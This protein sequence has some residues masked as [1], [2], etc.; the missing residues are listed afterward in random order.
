MKRLLA[1]TIAGVFVASSAAMS[2]AQENPPIRHLVYDFAV[3]IESTL[4]VHDSG[5]GQGG[6][7]GGPPGIPSGTGVNDV[8]GGTSDEGTITVDVRQQSADGGLVVSVSEVAKNARTAK[9]ALCALY[10]YNL[11]VVC[12]PNVK[13]NEEEIALLRVLGRNFVSGAG[14]H[15]LPGLHR[16]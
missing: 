3:G 12:D 14:R 8:R 15:E 4:T 7:R 10:G 2:P 13:I 1:L 9:P 16:A 11:T 5:I 6:E